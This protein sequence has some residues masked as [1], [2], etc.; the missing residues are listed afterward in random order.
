ML[1][2]DV[3]YLYT[4]ALEPYLEFLCCEPIF[5]DLYPF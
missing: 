1:A 5:G 4:I 3:K 2:L